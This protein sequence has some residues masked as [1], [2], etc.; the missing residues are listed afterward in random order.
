MKH[1]VMKAFLG[2]FVGFCL[3]LGIGIVYTEVVQQK[4]CGRELC[5]TLAQ[6]RIK[7]GD[8]RTIAIEKLP[9]AW[10]HRYCSSGANNA[11]DIFFFGSR[12]QQHVEVVVIT[13]EIQD[14][15]AL[16]KYLGSLENYMLVAYS[17]C[18]PPGT[19]EE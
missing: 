18:I 13:Y 11:I 7:L 12:R 16:V 6:S 17:D 9:E 4:P 19:F 14:G 2:S 5:I 1:R 10:F 15:K 3:I 8:E